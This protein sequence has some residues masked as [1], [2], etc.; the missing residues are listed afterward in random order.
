MGSSAERV[1]DA[2]IGASILLGGCYFLYYFALEPQFSHLLMGI[3][4]CI[5]AFYFAVKHHEEKKHWSEYSP[6]VITAAAILTIVALGLL[7][8]RFD[9]PG[10]FILELAT[11]VVWIA[12]LF[13]LMTRSLYLVLRE[14]RFRRTGD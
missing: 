3:S 2:I 13:L 1:L 7:Y 6:L 4:G 9:N 8:A 14:A 11:S 10:S 12:V 5:G